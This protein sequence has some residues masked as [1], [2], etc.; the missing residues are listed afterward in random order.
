VGV[1]AEPERIVGG[2][3]R[4]VAPLGAGGFGRVWKAHDEALDVHVAVKE[5][6]L[7]QQAVAEAEHRERVIRAAR[8]AR[9]AA[10]LRDHPHIVAVHDVVVEDGTPWIVMRLVDGPSLEERLRTGGPLPSPLVAEMATALLTALKA[11]HAAGIVHR[12]LKPANVMLAEDGQVLLT[13]FGIAVHET[14]TRLTATGG[15]IGSAEYMAPERLN[16][17]GDHP[18]GDLFS[19]GV[20]LYEAVEGVSPFRRDTPTATMAAVAMDDPPPPRH[21]DPVLASLIIALLAKNPADRPTAGSTLAMLRAMPETQPSTVSM[22]PA[23]RRPGPPDGTQ[24]LLAEERRRRRH[25]EGPADGYRIAVYCSLVLF[26]LV[27][28]LTLIGLIMTWNAHPGDFRVSSEHYPDAGDTGAFKH[29]Q[30]IHSWLLAAK[31]LSGVGLVTCWILWFACVRRLADRFAPGRLRYR[32]GMA[33][34]GWFVPIGNLFLPKQ[35]AD[36]V[37]HASSAQGRAPAPS[38]PLNTW[39]VAWLVTFLT[40]PLF[41][42]PSWFLIDKVVDPHKFE[43]SNGKIEYWLTLDY[44]FGGLYWI[45]VACHFLVVPLAVITVLYIRRLTAMQTAKLRR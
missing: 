31:V 5:V 19:L 41:W 38:R 23:T 35:I 10:R 20:T 17:S 37:W 14:D 28:V 40:W 33:V 22:A 1:Q 4:L 44:Q 27:S 24:L 36:D 21:A 34:A 18:A 2:R 8:E 12:D 32:P 45:H 15:V 29:W 16:G 7:P 3:Y 11:A 25:R 30:T 43:D 6:R 13:D 42:T 26:T 39:W 9:N